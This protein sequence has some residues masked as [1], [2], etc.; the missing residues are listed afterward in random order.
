[1]RI[2]ML[3]NCIVLEVCFYS[4]L[5]TMVSAASADHLLDGHSAVPQLLLRH[6]AEGIA[7]S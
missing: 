5:R 4:Q 7:L 2:K 3:E 1:M 6:S